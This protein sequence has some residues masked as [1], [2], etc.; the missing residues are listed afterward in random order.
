MNGNPAA[1]IDPLGLCGCGQSSLDTFVDTFVDNQNRTNEALGSLPAIGATLALNFLA[2]KGE[3]VAREGLG[4][5]PL[6]TVLR[7]LSTGGVATQG[8]IG[9]IGSGLLNLAE[10]YAYGLAAKTAGVGLGSLAVAAVKTIDEA[11]ECP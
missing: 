3:L 7:S 1:S 5:L 8:L 4:A 11:L 6:G 10:G 9:S 2:G